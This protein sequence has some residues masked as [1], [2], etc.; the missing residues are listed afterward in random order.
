MPQNQQGKINSNQRLNTKIY[1][2]V[3]DIA[4]SLFQFTNETCNT[5]STHKYRNIGRHY[6]NFHS[7]REFKSEI[8]FK[9]LITNHSQTPQKSLSLSLSCHP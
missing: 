9:L 1:R 2:N 3:G 4:A 7:S 5:L 8:L 6:L